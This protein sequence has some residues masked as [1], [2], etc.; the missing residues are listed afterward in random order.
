MNDADADMKIADSITQFARSLINDDD[1]DKTITPINDQLRKNRRDAMITYLLQ[2]YQ[3]KNWGVTDADGL[4]ELF[5][6]DVQMG[7][8][9]QT[10][11]IKS[12]ISAVQVFVQRALLG[13][14]PTE[15]DHAPFNI[16]VTRWE[17]M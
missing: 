3:I 8:Q 13:L 4:F 7:T 9:I 17:W 16:D 5:L 1:W 10:S 12:A 15:K 14:E 6:I 11:R 2:Q